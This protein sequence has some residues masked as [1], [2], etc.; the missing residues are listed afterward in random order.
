MPH[1][2]ILEIEKGISSWKL[3]QNVRYKLPE[4]YANDKVFAEEVGRLPRPHFF[5][6]FDDPTSS[7]HIS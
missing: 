7:S 3:L 2:K 1:G 6:D 4:T 5:V